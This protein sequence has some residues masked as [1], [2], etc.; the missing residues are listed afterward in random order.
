MN[1]QTK[2]VRIDPVEARISAREDA[3]HL[4]LIAPQML[5]IA[6]IA[7]RLDPPRR[8]YWP[9]E[10]SPARPQRFRRLLAAIGRRLRPH[11]PP[12]HLSEHLCRD[13]GLEWIP[14]EPPPRF[15]P[16]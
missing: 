9:E 7:G 13:I 11:S 4:P 10:S 6:E 1:A 8:S 12:R 2:P 15:W 5:I 3:V 14:P 16:W